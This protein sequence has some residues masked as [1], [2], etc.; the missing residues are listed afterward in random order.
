[1]LLDRSTSK[2]VVD[3]RHDP[4]SHSASM[5][6]RFIGW[7]RLQSDQEGD[8][9]EHAIVNWLLSLS[10]M[11][12]VIFAWVTPSATACTTDGDWDSASFSSSSL[13]RLV[14]FFV[15]AY[16]THRHSVIHS[17]ILSFSVEFF[18]SCS[19]D[20]Y[21]SMRWRLSTVCLYSFVS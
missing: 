5:Q 14:V 11:V 15:W 13:P 21:E 8:S 2:C 12:V 1:M 16:T 18:S 19:S 9:A 3:H 6:Q 17:C 4:N 20:Q 7:Q 10:N